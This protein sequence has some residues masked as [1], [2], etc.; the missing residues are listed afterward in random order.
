MEVNPLVVDVSATL[1]TETQEEKMMKLDH[2]LEKLR[3]L[4]P[5]TFG[6]L[7]SRNPADKSAVDGVGTWC[8]TTSSNK[9]FLRG[10]INV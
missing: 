2:V 1:V 9:R 10:R 4:D 7:S 8:E 6:I 5:K 3:S